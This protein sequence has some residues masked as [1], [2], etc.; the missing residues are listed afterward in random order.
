VSLALPRRQL[1]ATARA[2]LAFRSAF[3]RDSAMKAAPV[4]AVLVYAWATSAFVSSSVDGY[5][6]TAS[7][8][9]ISVLP[10]V[11]PICAACAAWEVGRLRRGGG[12]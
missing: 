1:R 5:G 12:L 4:I 9:V 11:A 2:P 7:M 6:L 3:R 10:F 8:R